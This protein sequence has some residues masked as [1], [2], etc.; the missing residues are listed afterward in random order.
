MM[1]LDTLKNDIDK[2]VT[3]FVGKPNIAAIY[4][5]GSTAKEK[6]R[7]TSDIDI[8]VMFKRY[9][10]EIEGLSFLTYVADMEGITNRKVDLVNFNTAD[11]LLR[12]QIIKYGRILTDKDTI[13]RVELMVRA[14]IDYEEYQPCYRLVQAEVA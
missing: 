4:L 10:P 13:A 11:P 7:S 6:Y 14:M 2:I 12:H 9:L 5:F 1:N 8:A 3:Y